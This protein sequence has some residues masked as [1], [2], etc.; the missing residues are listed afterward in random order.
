MN[1]PKTEA[2]RRWRAR[3]KQKKLEAEVARPD[4]FQT[5]FHEFDS[6]IGS[7]ADLSLAL[8]G[9]QIPFLEDD[10]GPLEFVINEATAGV[11]EPFPGTPDNSLGRAEVILGC[12]IS[13]AVEIAHSINTYKRMEIEAR[14]KE[15]EETDLS[16]PQKRKAALAELVRLNKMLDRLDK[17][18]RWSFQQWKVTD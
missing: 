8:A 2:Q 7:D 16:E 15:I 3:V 6:L 9:I 5:P 11:E 4:V 10:R 13:A 17:Q 12:L 1:N 14:A 18:V